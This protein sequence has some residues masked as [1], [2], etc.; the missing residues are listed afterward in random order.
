MYKGKTLNN[1]WLCVCRCIICP[2]ESFCVNSNILPRAGLWRMGEGGERLGD[3]ACFMG[4]QTRIVLLMTAT[5]EK[6]Y[7]LSDG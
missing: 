5:R 4:S 2:R 3:R 6:D 7:Q 1:W